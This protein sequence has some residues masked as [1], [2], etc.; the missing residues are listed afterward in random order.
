MRPH[1]LIVWV[2]HPY[3]HLLAIFMRMI[4]YGVPPCSRAIFL[5]FKRETPQEAGCKPQRQPRRTAQEEK[6]TVPGD[7]LHSRKE[8]K[9]CLFVNNSE[10]PTHRA[11]CLLLC[12]DLLLKILFLGS[13]EMAQQLRTL[14]VLPEVVSSNPSNHMVAYNYL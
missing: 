4:V 12:R 10:K 3:K 2:L 8:T 13:G 1:L 6:A 5:E 9:S 14:T 11:S 7:Q